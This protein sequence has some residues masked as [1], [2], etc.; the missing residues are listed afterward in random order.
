MDL[1]S[2]LRVVHVE[3]GSLSG[4]SK[5]VLELARHHDRTR[6]D[7]AVCA[8]SIAPEPAFADA[9]ARLGVPF[10]Q[11]KK[12][13]SYELGA[14]DR[15]ACALRSLRPDVVVLHGFGV[16]AYGAAAARQAGARAVVRVDH[17]PELYSPLHKLVSAAAAAS[18]DSTIVV[19]HYLLDYL[20]QKGVRLQRP[21]VIYNGVD[22]DRFAG[23]KRAPFSD[24]KPR[25]IMVAR[26]D[27]AKDHATL[28]EAMAVLERRKVAL[29]LTLAGEGPLR[30][31]L[32]AQAQALGVTGRV[33]FVGRGDDLPAL[34]AAS[35][36]AVLSTHYE[37]FGLVVVEA[38][39]CGRPVV[40]TG[41]AAIPELIRDGATGL[42]V[43]PRDPKRLADALA[44][45]VQ[46][47]A[48]ARALGEAGRASARARFPLEP[49]V[50]AFEAHLLQHERSARAGRL[51]E[52]VG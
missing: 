51:R 13:S 3:G 4:S 46:N 6:I 42:L 34:I 50:R 20:A 35:D 5:V 2:P 25:A 11:V 9:V 39:A 44:S 8:F 45:L 24:G 21:E 15:L 40:A 47:P 41:V 33:A 7:P 31:E 37:G 10:A 14:L 52:S 23:V 1:A 19:S 30:G 12:R 28:L 48:R 49:Q 18:V 38:Q 26:L 32:E 16:Y 36:I 27:V 43:P 17:Q 29:D 22:F